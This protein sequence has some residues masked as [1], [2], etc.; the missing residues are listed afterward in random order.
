MGRHLT[1]ALGAVALAL[2]VFLFGRWASS[3]DNDSNSSAAAPAHKAYASASRNAPTRAG[4][5]NQPY[6][7][8][9]PAWLTEAL[10]D[11]DPRVRLNALEAWARESHESLN[12]ITR[13]L[14][15]PDESVRARAQELFDEALAGR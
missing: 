3:P 13:A 5:D 7:K 15:D 2:V 8:D 10:D 9:E 11:P 6:P 1:Y 4:G 14:V 12:P